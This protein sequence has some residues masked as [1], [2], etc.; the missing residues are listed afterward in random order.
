MYRESK[1]ASVDLKLN[2]LFTNP[3]N[4]GKQ[5]PE[6]REFPNL[7]M[8]RG[9]LRG[10]NQPPQNTNPGASPK[11]SAQVI[12]LVNILHDYT[13]DMFFRRST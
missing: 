4:V 9:I 6:F 2:N 8:R 5:K 1:A 10:F 3:T 11:G 13:P 12:A 7:G